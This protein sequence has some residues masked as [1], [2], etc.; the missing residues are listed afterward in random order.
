MTFLLVLILLTLFLL[1]VF[2]RWL[3]DT[4]RAGLHRGRRE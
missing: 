3:A 2:P 1:F 4:E